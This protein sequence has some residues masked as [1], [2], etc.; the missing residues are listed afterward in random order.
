MEKPVFVR[1]AWYIAAESRELGTQPLGRLLLKEPVVLYRRSD[2]TPVALEDRCCH[3]RAPLSHGRVEGDALRCGY[4]GFVFEPGGRC[5]WVP[6]TDRIPSSAR[7][8]A[9]PVVEK[10]RWIWVWMGDVA[11]ADPARIPDLFQNDSPAWASASSVLPVKA[12]Y[13]LLV[14]NLM[15]LSHVAFTHLNSIG[16]AEDIDPDLH[17]ERGE[18]FAR[19]TRLALNLSPSRNMVQRGITYNMDVKKVMTFL[20]P[21]HVVID[22]T[23][24]EAN[25]PAGQAPRIAAHHLILNSMTP[26]TA[27]SCRYY[28][29]NARDHDIEDPALTE[30][31]RKQVAGAFEED[32]AMIEAQQRVIDLDPSAPVVNVV[33]D[34]GGVHARRIV[35][36]LLAEE[37]SS[38]T[39]G[40]NVA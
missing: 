38:G 29:A 10:H 2:G 18:D 35:E 33:G 28:W 24:S 8:R 23:R 11:K 14:E 27:T 21:C 4:H 9:Y 25:P 7:V 15:D 17:W 30:M 1:N 12:D 6:G 19:G 39:P 16:S 36:R 31:V 20:P 32:K 26:E 13:F 22:I 37:R 34:A 5:T 3:R 40:R